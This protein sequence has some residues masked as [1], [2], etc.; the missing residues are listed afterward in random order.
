[1]FF[2]II[3]HFP[4]TRKKNTYAKRR[5]RLEPLFCVCSFGC[6]GLC[7]A[8]FL[9]PQSQYGPAE[10]TAEQRPHSPRHASILHS[11]LSFRLSFA[12]SRPQVRQ[13]RQGVLLHD[14]PQQCRK[15]LRVADLILQKPPILGIFLFVPPVPCLVPVF[16]M[17]LE[18]RIPVAADG[19]VTSASVHTGRGADKSCVDMVDPFAD[20]PSVTDLVC[21]LDLFL[22]GC[23]TQISSVATHR[24]RR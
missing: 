1:M 14:R 13:L 2:V 3:R 16:G 24:K 4:G 11:A 7:H 10:R 8:F 9:Y 22:Q 15:A 19:V 5:L 18:V 12:P 20:T 17:L 6:C 21:S 23:L